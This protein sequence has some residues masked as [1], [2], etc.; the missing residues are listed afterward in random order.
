[1]HLKREVSP[2][3]W[4]IERKGTTYLIKPSHDFDRG[5]PILII[6]RDMLELAKDRKEVKKALTSGQVFLNHKRVV[7]EK[8]NALLFDILTLA[9]P[10]S[11][12]SDK[13][14]YYRIEMGENKKFKLQEVSE[15]EAET[16][17]SKVIKKMKL[18]GNKTQINLSDGRNFIS[19]VKCKTN[20]SLLINLKTKKIVKCIELQK[21]ANVAVF[22][23][24][25]TGAR[26]IIQDIDEEN[27]IV[28]IQK[29]NHEI[30]GALIKQV[31][32][33]EK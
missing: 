24:K 26:G 14:Q 17:C 3:N 11:S 13:K 20:D 7:D 19:N 4:P 23:G 2:K 18:K 5:V 21:N 6:I 22:A 16:K 1:M 29:K 12:S 31:I 32:A 9:P 15:N 25:H 10:K 8:N 33:V 30:I 27:K 28:K